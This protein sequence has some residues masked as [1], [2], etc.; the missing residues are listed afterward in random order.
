MK[1]IQT[2]LSDEA[3]VTAI[4][5]N[6]CEFF[7]HLSR[8]FP[9]EHFQNT[10][11]M[12][13]RTSIEHPWFNGVLSTMPPEKDDEAFIEETLRYFQLKDVDT[14]T[15]W[16]EPWLRRADWEPVL[17]KYKFVYSDD[18]PGMAVDLQALK[19]ARAVDGLEVRVVADEESLHTWAYVF[20]IGYGLHAAWEPSIYD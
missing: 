20:T 14:L 3:L 18:T 1:N 17:A 9:E 5:A 10:R 15:W 2:D 12:R 7:R 16:M 4:R 6:L 11:F 19:D 13:W 8:S